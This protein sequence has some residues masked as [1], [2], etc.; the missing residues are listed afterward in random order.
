[1]STTDFTVALVA[2]VVCP[3]VV[4]LAAHYRRYWLAGLALF[5]AVMGLMDALFYV[6]AH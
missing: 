6:F 1:V 5:C 3:F 4:L 2:V